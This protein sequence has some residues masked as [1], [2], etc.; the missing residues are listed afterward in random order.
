MS[1][2]LP[3]PTTKP[4]L[5]LKMLINTIDPQSPYQSTAQEILRPLQDT[6]DRVSKQVEEFAK[7]LDKFV[8]N[9]EPTDASLWED[10]LVLLDRYSKIAQTRTTTTAANDSDSQA[11]KVLLESD[12]WGLVRNLLYCN[13]P[14]TVNNAQ[15]AQ[16]SRLAGLHRYSS[17]A[18][19]WGAFLDSDVVAQEYECI[20]SWLQDRAADSSPP[21]HITLKALLEKSDRGDG[22]WSAGPI[23]TQTA[24]KQQKRTRALSQPLDPS[25]PNLTRSHTRKADRKPL[26]AQLDPDSRTRESAALQKEDEY[27]EQAAWRTCWEMLRRGQSAAEIQSW[28]AERREVWRYAVI[29]GCGPN[30]GEMANSPW[31]RILNLASNAEWSHRCH[32]LA[33]NPAIQDVYQKAVYGVLC[34]DAGASKAATHTIEDHLFAIFNALLIQRYQHYIQAYQHRLG[35]PGATVYSP[36]PPATAHIRQYAA[37]AQSDPATKDEVHTP[38]KLLELT[39]VSKDFDTFFLSMGR[40]A[41]QVAYATDQGSHLMKENEDDVS[42]IARINAQDQDSVRMVVHLQLLLQALGFLESS[43]A[44]HEYEME[45]N[46]ASYI[47]WLEREGKFSLLPLYAS[48]LSNERIPRVLGAI[49]INVTDRR[50]RDLQVKLMKQY[51]IDVSE[52]AYGIFYLANFNTIQ[53]LRNIEEIPTLPRITVPGAT[54]STAQLRV[55]PGLMTGEVSEEDEKAIRSVEWYR[56]VDAEHWGSAAWSVSILYKTFLMDGN[57]VALRQLLDRVSLSEMS[58]SAVGMNLNFADEEPPTDEDEDEDQEMDDDHIRP[59]SPSRK[60]KSPL[61]EHPLTRAGTDRGSLAYKSMVWRQLEQ[62]VAAMDSLDVFQEIADNLEANR[63][64]PTVVRSCKR[65]MK[66]AL[67]DVRQTMQPLFDEEFMCRFQDDMEGVLLTALRNHYIPECILAYNSVLYCAGHYVSRVWL[68]E[69]LELSQVVAQNAMLT[70]AFVAGGRMQ[71][72]VRAFA[73]DSR[74]LLEATEQSGTRSK[75]IKTEKGNSDIWKVTW[76]QQGPIDLEALD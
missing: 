57:F 68:V 22:V 25:T 37:K 53:K 59:M 65:D 54:T 75:K 42:E 12:L 76:K 8:V 13:S 51:K 70:N 36:Q 45:N 2:L 1:S 41:S 18:E 55:R 14:D 24:I 31:L 72:L 11:Q 64:N 21:I 30:T 49:L 40:A 35:N 23:Y 60:R 74:A 29:R 73:L 62:L 67:D 6:A 10:A 7:A 28:W 71:E 34:G 4:P 50:E 32:S 43:Y 27:Y 47:G 39:V 5:E 9:R 44:E 19:L 20:L 16:E 69:C 56:Y 46:I 33:H 63:K 15:I 3:E 38:H 52:V 58:L 26:V 48:K 61:H 17:N 66:K